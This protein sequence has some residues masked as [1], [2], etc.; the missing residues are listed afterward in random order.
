[1][2]KTVSQQVKMQRLQICETCDN[3]IKNMNTCRLCGCYIPAKTLFAK[4]KCPEE[5][6]QES[7]P[8]QT[9]INKI[10]EL[11]LESWNK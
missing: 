9:I 3:F 10:E 6:W 4:T 7:E 5:K 8:G 1:M 11:I 2:L